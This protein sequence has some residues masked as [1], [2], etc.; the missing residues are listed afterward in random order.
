MWAM[1]EYRITLY[2]ADEPE[3]VETV[4]VKCNN[5]HYAIQKAVILV[6]QKTRKK[7]WK[8]RSHQLVSKAWEKDILTQSM[9]AREYARTGRVPAGARV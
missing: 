6:M 5:L 7:G 4:K 1:N 3:T 9:I 2:L 8:Y